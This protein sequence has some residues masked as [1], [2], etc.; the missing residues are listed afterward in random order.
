VDGF[1][2]SLTVHATDD[3]TRFGEI[4][5]RANTRHEAMMETL[6]RN[7]NVATVA[8]STI[9]I[10]FAHVK[11]RLKGVEARLPERRQEER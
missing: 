4:E 11:E 9:Q 3:A 6:N 8:V 10:E 2:T 7:A 1:Q 5:H